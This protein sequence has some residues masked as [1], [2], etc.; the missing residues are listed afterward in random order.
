MPTLATTPLNAL[1]R[2]LGARMVAFAGFEMPV[3]FDRGVIAEHEWTRT[4]AG[5]FD[6]SHMGQI[7][8]DGP[9]EALHTVVPTRLDTLRSGRQR[10]SVLTTDSGGILDD[11]MI[12]RL[13]DRFLFVVNAAAQE[14]VFAHLTERLAGRG[15]LSRPHRALVALQGPAAEGALSSLVPDVDA[16]VFMDVVET[17]FEG[18]PAIV[19]RSGYTG[20]DGFEIAL[21][22]DAAEA[23]ARALIA[24][25]DVAPVG[26]GARDTLR[27]EA[28]LPLSG[29]DIGPEVTPIE[30]GLAFV[31][32]RDGVDGFPGAERILAQL[33][34]GAPRRR[35]GLKPS[36]R[37]PVR[38][39]T[40]LKGP[41]GTDAGT[42]TSGG[43]GPSVGAPVAMG[44]VSGQYS[45]PGT[46]LEA[47]VR[48]RPIDIDVVEL[49]FVA[50]R[51][52]RAPRSP[53]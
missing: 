1:H 10:Y 26:L 11:L 4:H 18:V 48:S 2:E 25:D 42:V 9:A 38:G 23:F 39:G 19:T 36:G 44:L 51:Y 13:A 17:Q 31:V 16:L 6:V 29:T 30:A 28:G 50:H 41:D 24:R 40:P 49:P 14:A 43:F 7:E 46:R 53:A 52:R 3:Q 22:V 37:A 45:S 20:E 8:F 34:G 33:D 15:S 12:A 32:R 5:L 27:L 47:E 21:P 35:V